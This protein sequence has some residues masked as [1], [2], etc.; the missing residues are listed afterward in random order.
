MG[1]KDRGYLRPGLAADLV[2]FDPSMVQDHATVETPTR[3][4]TGVS[5]VWVNGEQAWSNGRPTGNYPG[6]A[7]RRASQPAQSE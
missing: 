3:L 7:L 5:V 2:L 4:A 6:K 1:F